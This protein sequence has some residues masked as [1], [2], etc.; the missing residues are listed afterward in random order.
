MARVNVTRVVL[1]MLVSEAA[2]VERVLAQVI[3][4][5]RVVVGNGWSELR[6]AHDRLSALCAAADGE[7][8]N[9]LVTVEDGVVSLLTVPPVGAAKPVEDVLWEVVVGNVGTTYRGVDGV[10]AAR[11]FIDYAAGARGRAEGELVTLMRDG[12]VYRE[13]HARSTESV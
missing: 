4:G 1:P 8:V 11:Q 2:V 5:K 13:L 9:P 7:T 12:E 3:A 6:W 10:E